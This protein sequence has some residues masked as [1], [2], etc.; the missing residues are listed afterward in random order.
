MADR[1]GQLSV[2]TQDFEEF[3]RFVGAPKTDQ[4]RE[5]IRFGSIEYEAQLAS[6]WTPY[7]FYINGKESH[8]GTN[9]FQ[10]VKTAEGWK[11]QYILDTRRR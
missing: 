10:L 7:T 8:S 11:I 5:E 2:I 9:S 1:Q 3:V 4:Y 6:V